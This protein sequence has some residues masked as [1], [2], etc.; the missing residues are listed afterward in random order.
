[1]AVD[2]LEPVSKCDIEAICKFLEEAV[3]NQRALSL[4]LKTHG[5]EVKDKT[6]FYCRI[7][8]A[9]GKGFYKYL[10][11]KDLSWKHQK[12]A[13]LMKEIVN[14]DECNDRY[15][16]ARIYQTLIFKLSNEIHIPG[17]RTVYL[18]KGKISLS[19]L[20]KKAPIGLQKRIGKLLNQ[21]A[22]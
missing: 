10:F 19:H 11:N 20:P 13:D 18:V 22:N 17:E 6:A 12:L 16:Q 3:K 9:G 14:E 5:S 21:T 7:L 4:P 2:N 1:M 15:G 8:S